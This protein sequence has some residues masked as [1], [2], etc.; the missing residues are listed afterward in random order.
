[1]LGKLLDGRYKVT[2]VLSAGG[3]GETYI[4]EDTRRPG[5]PKCVL[6]LLK[7]AI[8]EAYYLQ[9]ARRLFL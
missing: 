3:F 5:N 7:P 9:V 1:M 4:A 8:S 2:Q 6:K